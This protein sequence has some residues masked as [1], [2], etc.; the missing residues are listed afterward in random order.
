MCNFDYEFHVSKLPKFPLPEGVDP[1]EF[2]RE[3]CY[4]GMAP[5]YKVFSDVTGEG[6]FYR[7]Y[8]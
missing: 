6:F 2:L 3:H 8:K 5:R 7:I 1:Y 4:K